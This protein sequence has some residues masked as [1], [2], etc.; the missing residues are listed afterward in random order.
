M[1]I[2]KCV[3]VLVVN[4]SLI[5]GYYF[6]LF[7]VKGFYKFLEAFFRP[8]TSHGIFTSHRFCNI[9]LGGQA[10]KL[11]RVSDCALMSRN[12]SFSH[13]YEVGKSIKFILN[14]RHTLV[15]YLQEISQRSSCFQQ[16]WGI[17]RSYT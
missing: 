17:K 8:M 14:E 6:H 2:A 16:L 15:H 9:Q 3:V 13:T 5:H 10:Y 7:S 11:E 1:A 12:L 4:K